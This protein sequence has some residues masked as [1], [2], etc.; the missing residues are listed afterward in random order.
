VCLFLDKTVMLVSIAILPAAWVASPLTVLGCYAASSLSVATWGFSRVGFRALRPVLPSRDVYRAMVLFSFPLLLSS[1]AGLLGTNWFD[2]VILKRYVPI[3]SIGVYSLATQLA[4]VVQQ[5][6]IIFSTLL[7]PH[8]SVMVAEGQEARIRTFVERLLPYWLLGT[9][10]LFGLIVLGAR[11]GLVLV[12]GRAFGGAAPALAALMAATSALALFNACAPLV[13]A[14]GSTWAL[15][16]IFLLS[17]ATNVVFDFA[18]IPSFGVVGS[19]IATVLA[20][21]TSAMLVLVFVQKRL[22]GR[23]LRLGWFCAPVLV[24]CICFWMLDGIWFYAG[25]SVATAGCVLA[26]ISW[27]RLFRNDDVVFLKELH[28]PMPFG[29]R[30]GSLLGWRP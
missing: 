1:W 6:T 26:L 19:A 14:Y 28:L 24:A 18:L 11:M 17:A 7:L 23:V 29:L 5:I 4:G 2:L 16:A 25:T 22:G 8:L 10:V 13:T 15:T 12:F 30:A 20:Y 27:F 3:S 21:A 9:S